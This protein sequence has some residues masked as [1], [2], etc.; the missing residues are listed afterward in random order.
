[1]TLTGFLVAFGGG[2]F[3]A[4]IGALPAFIMF[5]GLMVIVGA[6]VQLATGN[7]DFYGVPFGPFIGPHVGGF[8]SGVAALAYATSKGKFDNG[9]NIAPGMMGLNSPDVLLVGGIFGILGYVIQWAFSLVPAFGPGYAWT[10]TVALTVVVSAI[11]TR[12]VFGK[13]GVFGTVKPGES[14]YA[15]GSGS[16]WVPWQS[17]PLQLLVIGLGAGLAAGYLGSTLG[18]P[19]VMLSFGLAAFSLLALQFGVQIPVTHH[20]FLPAAIAAAASGSVIWGGIFGIVCAFVGEFMARTFVVHG[21][22]HIDPP[23]ATIAVMTTVANALAAF[24]VLALLHLP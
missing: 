17:E 18:A 1:M 11:I 20:I 15:T 7:A 21:D 6:G 13:T 10:D 22:T 4:A 12:L 19:G 16:P 2:V 8:A 9:R 14:R 3:G 24:G 23:A 5:V